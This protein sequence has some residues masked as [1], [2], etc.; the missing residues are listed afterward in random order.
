M[1]STALDQLRSIKNLQNIWKVYRQR[2][3]RSA[4]G[5]DGLTPKQLD[6]N[7]SINLSLI[8]AKLGEG[9]TYSRLRGVCVPKQDPNKFRVICVPT[10][11]DRIVQRAVLQVIE[12]KSE[13]LRIA[14]DVSF[15]FVKD[16]PGRKRGVP[17]AR[18]AAISHRHKRNWGFKA[19][20]TAFFDRIPREDLTSRFEKAFSLKSL[21]PVVRGAIS[22]EIDE[23]D[24][25]V[26]RVVEQNG[27]VAGRG[28]RQG[29]PLSP[30]LSNFLL[31]DFD[32][33]FVKHGFDMVRYADDFVV[34]ASSQAEC[35][36]IKAM[37]AAELKKL[38]LE[39]SVTKTK[40]CRPDEAIEFLGLEL[41]LLPGTSTYG[42]TITEKQIS[43][44][45]EQ[46]TNHHDLDFVV[47]KGLNLGTILRRLD[48]MTAGYRVAYGVADNR[49]EF[50][51][52]LEQWTHNCVQRIFISIFGERAIT[53]LSNN[54]RK[55]LMLS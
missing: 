18:A 28:L 21:L 15:G 19:D 39:L 32:A 14:N 44:I 17:A 49:D 45:K 35:E 16:T 5:I 13:R 22:C 55:F 41:G 27:I 51:N 20:I 54:Q 29:M 34:F 1:A 46:F 24:P 50:F 37:T 26:R 2:A 10:I 9:Y 31:R 36:E 12:T 48:N 53:S 25:R 7:L 43:K 8:R 40:I 52:L 11:H 38:G 33:A 47:S 42:L 3:I 6:E 23:G 30:I 4:A